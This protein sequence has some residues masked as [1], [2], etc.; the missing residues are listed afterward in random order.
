[1]RIID[2][3]NATITAARKRLI[4]R[5]RRDDQNEAT[6]AE[7]RKRLGDSIKAPSSKRQKNAYM[8]EPVGSHT[9]VVVVRL[10][11]NRLDWDYIREA[12]VSCDINGGLDLEEVRKQLCVQGKCRVSGV[13]T[14]VRNQNLT[15]LSAD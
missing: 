5:L 9:K 8:T 11:K 4:D 7:P 6:I 10:Y 2:E 3:T 12:R 15:L 13:A 14:M 1:V